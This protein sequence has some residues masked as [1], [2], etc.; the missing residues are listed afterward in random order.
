MIPI[1]RKPGWKLNDNDKVVNN[2]FNRCEKNN[3]KCPCTHPEDDGD[4]HCPCA[5]YRIL[6][7]CYC[8]LYVKI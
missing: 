8:G 2:I 4:L 7:T 6:D 5:S 1:L 3:G